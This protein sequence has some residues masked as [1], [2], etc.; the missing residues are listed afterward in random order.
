MVAEICLQLAPRRQELALRTT[1]SPIR[2][3]IRL[4]SSPRVHAAWAMCENNKGNWA[5]VLDSLA[6]LR[7]LFGNVYLHSTSDSG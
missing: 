5:F 3:R 7:N 1:D 2:L 4:R 6:H